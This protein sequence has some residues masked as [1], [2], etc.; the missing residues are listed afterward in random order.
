MSKEAVC[1]FL[2][3]CVVYADASINRKKTREEDATEIQRWAAYRDFTAYALSEV[4]RGELDDWFKTDG[5]QDRKRPS[6]FGEAMGDDVE[7]I[8]TNYLEHPERAAWLSTLI[9]P[10]PV[11]LLSTVGENGVP[12]LCPVSSVA[13]LSNTPPLIGVSLSQ[14]RAGR[15]RDTLV[16]LRN[17]SK[18][19]A[20]V[21]PGTWDAAQLV[22]ETAEAHPPERSEWDGLSEAVPSP[23]D[24]PPYHPLSAAVLECEVAE[25]HPLPGAVATLA[26]LKVN[27]I[28]RPDEGTKRGMPPDAET[29]RPLL[30]Q[31]GWDRLTSGP[32]GSAWSFDVRSY[33]D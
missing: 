5:E 6:F 8:D 14:D 4:E 1:D 22:N 33:R 27:H 3:R 20:M 17:G 25:L 29:W 26:I 15:P 24:Y 23:N 2:R 9:A 31:Y 21:L 11:M 12:N 7:N 30:T 28:L 19:S 16:N 32:D 18:I 13:S 10:R